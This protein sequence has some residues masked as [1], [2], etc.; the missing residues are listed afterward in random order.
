MRTSDKSSDRERLKAL[1]QQHTGGLALATQA[2]PMQATLP[3]PPP[4]AVSKTE[5]V[6]LER[7]GQ[8]DLPKITWGKVTVR[9][10]ATELQK[11]NDVVIATQQAHRTARVT[12]SDVLRVALRRIKDNEAITA[13]NL[14]AVSVRNSIRSKTAAV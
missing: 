13:E 11:I 8:S 3:R 6:T 14:K 4:A 5:P 2:A 1:M 12:T 10:T 9:L 7:G